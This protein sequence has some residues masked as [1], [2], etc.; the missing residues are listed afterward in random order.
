MSET[1]KRKR[2]DYRRSRRLWI[3]L[4]TVLVVLATLASLALLFVY[5]Q[6]N[7]AYYIDY[8]ENGKVDYRVKLKPNLF[9][10]EEYLGAGQ[11]YVASLIDSVEANFSYTLT[12]ASPNVRYDYS[13]KID[14]ELLI[15][16]TK[17]GNTILSRVEENVAEKTF[18]KIGS[19]NLT[20][21]EKVT[22][23][24]ENYNLATQMFLEDLKLSGTK[25]ALIVR[26]HINVISTCDDFENDG[27][28]EYV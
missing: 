20:I 8:T 18:S 6:L 24:Y 10:E 27:S 25:A 14:T 3:T 23:G 5:H 11:A 7:K 12:M 13:Y 19:S 21:A 1:E 16:D 22:L 26:M 15:T 28:N 9:Y 17:S 4:L 2:T